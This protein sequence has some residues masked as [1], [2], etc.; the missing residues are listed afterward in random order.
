VKEKES[1]GQ[2]LTSIKKPT[3]KE[4]RL[5]VL[6]LLSKVAKKLK[7]SQAQAEKLVKKLRLRLLPYD[8]LKMLRNLI[9]NGGFT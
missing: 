6:A 3:I 8:S 2:C 9:R 7:L 1:G 5:N 4:P